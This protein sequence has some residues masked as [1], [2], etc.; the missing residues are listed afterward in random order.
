MRDPKPKVRNLLTL[1][2]PNMG[3]S[4]IPESVCADNNTDDFEDFIEH[5]ICS[6]L[7]YEVDQNAYGSVV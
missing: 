4:A 1:G 7:E 6:I 3:I 5:P 2:T